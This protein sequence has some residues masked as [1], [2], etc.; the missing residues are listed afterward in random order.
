MFLLEK[1]RPLIAKEFLFNKNI[2][3]QLANVASN[4]DIPHIIISGPSGG[5]KKTLVKFF[6]NIY[7]I[8]M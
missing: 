5:G 3:E 6:W 4:E 2:L 1:Y 7:M 8:Q